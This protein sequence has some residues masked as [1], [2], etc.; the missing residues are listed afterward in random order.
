MSGCRR[1]WICHWN[2]VHRRTRNHCSRYWRSNTVSHVCWC[3]KIH[4]GADCRN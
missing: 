4:W 2:H 3:W 1:H